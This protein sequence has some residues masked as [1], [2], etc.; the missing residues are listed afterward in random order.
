MVEKPKHFDLS[1]F[2]RFGIVGAEIR[3]YLGPRKGEWI[4]RHYEI[5]TETING[6]KSEVLYGITRK[7]ARDNLQGYLDNVV[8]KELI[9]LHVKENGLNERNEEKENIWKEINSVNILRQALKKGKLEKVTE[10]YHALMNQ[11]EGGNN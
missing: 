10:K 7:D 5:K 4:R 3:P 9:E 6:Q 8:I 1:V 11:N 2:E